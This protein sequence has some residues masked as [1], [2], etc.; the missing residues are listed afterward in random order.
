M[1]PPHS[2]DLRRRAVELARRGDTSLLRLAKD[3]RISRSC[4]HTWLKQ[5]AAGT[6]DPPTGETKEKLAEL[7]RRNKRLETENDVLRRVVELT[8]R[9]RSTQMIYSLIRE[10]AA[11]RVPV[12]VACRLLQVST[13]GYYDWLGRPEPPRVLRDR[14]L[15]KMIQR[16]HADSDGRYGSPRVHAEL[17]SDL[18]EVVSRKRVER[19]MREAGLQGAHGSPSSAVRDRDAARSLP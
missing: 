2:P 1:P 16:I 15:T 13:S 12:A 19:L 14:E 3:L 6:G 11:G 7:R 17:R 10:L 4:L 8:L 18:G 9:R 5:D